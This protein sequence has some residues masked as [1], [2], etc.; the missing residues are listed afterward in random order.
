MLKSLKKYAQKILGNQSIKK[1]LESFVLITS[2]LGSR[3]RLFSYI[4][5]V[6]SPIAYSREQ[7]TTLRGRCEFYKKM[8]GNT[9]FQ[10]Y[11]RRNIHRIEKGLLMRPHKSV[12]AS[13]YILPT[14]K[15]IDA[16]I[17]EIRPVD[18]DFHELFWIHNTLK[19]YF[20][21]IKEG[22][23]KNNEVKKVNGGNQAENVKVKNNRAKKSGSEK[24]IL[25]AQ[26]LQA[27]R[28]FNEINWKLV[29]FANTNTNTTDLSIKTGPYPHSDI[30]Q[31]N[32][33][34]EDL[35]KLGVQRRSVRWY[36]DKKVDKEIIDKALRFAR[37]S[38][39]A[40]NRLPYKFLIFNDREKAK[41][42][43]DLP[44]G[45]SG[46]AHNIPAIAVVIGDQQY[47][48]SPRDRHVI[49]IDSSLAA[50]SFIYA[51]ETEGVSSCVI[52]W[53]DFELLEMKLQ[54]ILN[55][56]PTEKAIMFIAFGYADP[57]GLIGVSGK[58][59]IGKIAQYNREIRI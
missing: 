15:S 27:E 13:K 23:V 38:P 54:R 41:K 48:F 55:L 39:S 11:I 53:P 28:I 24:Q 52:N 43:A 20:N 58:K 49:Y 25:P 16:Y 47:Y 29:L 5:H 3:N 9:S 21:V 19:T 33:K 10:P 57:G 45:A 35:Y 12:F 2:W 4:Y 17:E 59:D 22:A 50:M 18:R 26:I 44:F 37:L 56:Q 14:V 40:C 42:I 31:S 8:R 1:S 7:F 46:Y 30:S 36:Q 32:I 6:L 51:L 34:Y